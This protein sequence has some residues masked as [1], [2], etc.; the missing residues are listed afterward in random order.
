LIVVA[1]AGA[2]GTGCSDSETN[3]EPTFGEDSASVAQAI[4][5]CDRYI[6]EFQPGSAARGRAAVSSRGDVLLDIFGSDA[7]AARLP[8]AAVTALRSNPNIANIQKDPVRRPVASPSSTHEHAPYGIGMV[9]ADQLSDAAAGNRTVCIIDSGYDLGHDDLQTANVTGYPAS[10]DDVPWDEDTCGHGTHVAGTIA[11]LGNGQGVVGVNPSGALNIHVVRVFGDGCGWAYASDLAD[12]ARRCESAGA[13]VISMS[14]GCAA[15][16]PRRCSSSFEESTFQDLYDKGVLNV[17]AASND[18]KPWYSFPA[19]YGSVMSVAAID[20]DK[21]HASFS[22]TN[23][24][25]EVAAPGVSVWSTLPMGGC[26][27]CDPGEPYAAWDGTSMA[28]PHVAGVAALLWSYDTGLTNQQIRDALT[29]TAEDLGSAGRDD[30]YGHGLI[31]ADLALNYLGLSDG[32]VCG[33]DV[34]DDGEDASTCADCA[35]CEN[36]TCEEGEDGTTCSECAECG[37]GICELGETGLNC[38]DCAVCG[39]DTCEAGESGDTCAECATCGD[40]TCEAGEDAVNCSADCDAVCGNDLCE[41][42]ENAATCADC[43]VCGNDTCEAGEDGTECAECAECGNGT[44][45]A[46]ETE[47]SCVDDC[48]LSCTPE[49]QGCGVDSDCCSNKCKGKP[50]ARTCK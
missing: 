12:A 39:N 32:P 49:G 36:D 48:E 13:D 16:N 9:G 5:S 41:P 7:V 10:T 20:A 1:G 40:G 26:Y 28:T 33:D 23:D 27:Y 8:D 37:N 31:R 17:A 30:S 43:A 6:V 50:G 19:S 34:C 2:L 25:V 21:N 47:S 38:A 42:A 46:G 14:L 4:E 15:G 22:N 18:G 35:V 44:C 3:V 24:A 29:A 11:A 45:E